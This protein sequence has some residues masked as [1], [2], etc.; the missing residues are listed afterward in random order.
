MPEDVRVASAAVLDNIY[1]DAGVQPSEIAV[2][3]GNSVKAE[4]CKSTSGPRKT[5][6]SAS[7]IASLSRTPNSSLESLHRKLVTPSEEQQR[8]QIFSL[9]AA[10][11]NA[12][13]SDDFFEDRK[14]PV[15]TN[16]RNLGEALAAMS[17]N[18]Q[19]SAAEVYTR[20]LMWDKVSP[21]VVRDF[22]RMVAE[23]RA[24]QTGQGSGEVLS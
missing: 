1:K 17:S 22:A 20:S 9:S 3:H 11:Y 19:G 23:T 16:R 15:V 4:Q 7:E 5:T 24:V 8:N 6:L 10:Q 18:T 21:E 14:P 13:T 2:S 12:I